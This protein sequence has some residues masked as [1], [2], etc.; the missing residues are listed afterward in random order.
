MRYLVILKIL[1]CIIF[2]NS[3]LF[4]QGYLRNDNVTTYTSGITLNEICAN[5]SAFDYNADGIISSTSDKDEFVEIVNSS[6]QTINIGGWTLSDNTTTYLIFPDPTSINPG[7]SIVV[8]M[9]GADVSNF[10]PGSGNLVTSTPAGIR[11][12]NS[13]DVIGLKN[14][15]G[16]YISVKWGTG[17]LPADFTTGATLV[18]TEVTIS[19]SWIAGQSQSRNPDYSGS[20]SF[21]PTI[22]GTVDWSVD[23]TVTLT[24]PQA[25]PGRKYGLDQSL[26]VTLSSFRA[27]V[28][29]GHVLLQW[30]TE[31][32]VENL[33][34]EIYRSLMSSTGFQLLDSYRS[35]P[36]LEAVAW[37]GGINAYILRY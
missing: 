3:L 9:Y 5:G 18:G 23:H 12:S 31:S 10:N 4:A 16:L 6:D 26:P 25:S 1:V 22:T 14:T 7:K 19:N 11:L 30:R 21:H 27:V 2:F 13:D 20:W 29:H 36:A 37:G 15:N 17:V 8:Y 35:N 24:D 34:F 28:Q 32:E 33:G